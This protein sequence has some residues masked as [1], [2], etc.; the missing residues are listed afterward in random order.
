MLVESLTCFAVAI[1]LSPTTGLDA[2]ATIKPIYHSALLTLTAVILFMTVK[3]LLS[4]Q[5]CAQT[6]PCSLRSLSLLA[7]LSLDNPQGI[8][9]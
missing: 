4:H 7:D 9:L 3:K 5:F 1:R 2:V 8:S 6:S